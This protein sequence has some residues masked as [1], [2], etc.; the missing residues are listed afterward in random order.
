MGAAQMCLALG[1]V[2]KNILPGIVGAL[3]FESETD[4]DRHLAFVRRSLSSRLLLTYIMGLREGEVLESV[5]EDWYPK[6]SSELEQIAKNHKEV[7]A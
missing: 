3:L 4:S 2:P 5:L 7:S 6:I 1:F